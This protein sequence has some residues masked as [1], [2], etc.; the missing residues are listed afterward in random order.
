MVN[1]QLKK[2]VL[3]LCVLVLLLHKDRYGYELVRHISENIDI[4]RGTLYPLLKKMQKDDY[5]SIYFVSSTEGPQRKYYS[6]TPIGRE[7]ME[8][9]LKEWMHFSKSVTQILNKNCVSSKGEE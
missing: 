6:I 1:A 9:L 4:A 3:E 5:V 2:G 8:R 7:R